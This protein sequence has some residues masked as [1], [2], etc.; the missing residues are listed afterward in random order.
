VAVI[1]GHGKIFVFLER[2]AP[3]LTAFLARK[4]GISQRRQR[5]D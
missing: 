3:W 5:D 1:T 2:H 4:L